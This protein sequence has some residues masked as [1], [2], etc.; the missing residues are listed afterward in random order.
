M[1]SVNS[2]A[3]SK[4]SL[5][6]SW[7]DRLV[8]FQ[9]ERGKLSLLMELIGIDS[10]EQ[11]A[12]EAQK[13]RNAESAYVRQ[14]AWGAK[15]S[16]DDDESKGEDV[17]GHVLGDMTTTHNYPPAKS[18]GVASMILGAGLLATGIGIP[19]GAWMLA[20]GAKSAIVKPSEPP[21]VLVP[22]PAEKPTPTEQNGVKV[23][24]NKLRLVK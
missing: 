2:S 22:Q 3:T 4:P 10:M 5:W 6:V 1:A 23:W 8:E 13:N 9:Q 20:S 7:K 21:A 17:G 11:G 19:A 14:K 24:R 16:A 15:D 18:S 12:A